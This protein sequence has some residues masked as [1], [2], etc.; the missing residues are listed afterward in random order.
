MTS[1][2]LGKRLQAYSDKELSGILPP[3]GKGWQAATLFQKPLAAHIKILAMQHR[4]S[5][6]SVI[7]YCVQRVLREEGH[8]PFL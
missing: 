2:S 6:A 7:R 3:I 1:E 5:E 4:V 8:N